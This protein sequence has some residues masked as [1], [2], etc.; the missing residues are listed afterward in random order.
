MVDAVLGLGL[1]LL[2]AVLALVLSPPLSRT[3]GLD[4]GPGRWAG[5]VIMA[6]SV[7]AACR[8]LEHAVGAA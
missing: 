5:I 8:L 7:A 6:L 3:A 2:A 4:G 1:L